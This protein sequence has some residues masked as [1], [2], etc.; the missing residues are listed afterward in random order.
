M[1]NIFKF[2][3]I[4]VLFK[5]SRHYNRGQRKYRATDYQGAIAEYTIAP[6]INP[7]FAR[8]ILIGGIKF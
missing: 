4:S 3:P 1:E 5:S 6:E 8:L 7:E 2:K